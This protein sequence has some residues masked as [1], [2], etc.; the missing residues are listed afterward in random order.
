[1]FVVLVRLNYLVIQNQINENKKNRQLQKC[2]S[3]LYKMFWLLSHKHYLVLLL[4]IHVLT[5]III[6]TS[7]INKYI[8]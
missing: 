4:L 1:M 3:N 8:Q 5:D 2:I 7:L 6:M